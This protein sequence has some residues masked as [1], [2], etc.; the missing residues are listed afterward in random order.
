VTTVAQQTT[1]HAGE[2]RQN[3]QK[4]IGRMIRSRFTTGPLLHGKTGQLQ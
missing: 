3:K 4:W 2:I 1:L